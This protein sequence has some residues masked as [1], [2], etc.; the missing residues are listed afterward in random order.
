MITSDIGDSSYIR[1]IW[2]PGGTI[3]VIQGE[4][5]NYVDNELVSYDKMG[6]WNSF[7][8]SSYSKK[9][10]VITIYRMPEGLLIGV[11]TQQAQL[12]RKE[13]MV[14]IATPPQK[15][16]VKSF[17]IIYIKVGISR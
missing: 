10:I 7:I 12:N 14:K 3:S 17:V 1:K 4:W 5:Q 13:S 11:Y 15:R 9:I 6:R 16:D 8:I 2:L